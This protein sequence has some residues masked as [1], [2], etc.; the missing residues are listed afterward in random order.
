M[1][2]LQHEE[3]SQVAL[4]T[5]TIAASIVTL[6]KTSSCREVVVMHS[7]SYLDSHGSG[8][9]CKHFRRLLMTDGL[10]EL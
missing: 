4:A 7:S 2:K 10:D 8:E 5:D 3:S 9:L 1:M 6:Q